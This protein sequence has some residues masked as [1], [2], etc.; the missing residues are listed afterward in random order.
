M[1]VCLAQI[2]VV[3]N[4]PE[5]N[6]ARMLEVIA[7][8]KRSHVDLVVFPEMCVGGY[9]LGDKWREPSY[10]ANMT[11]FNDRLRQA[12]EGIAIAYGNVF[13]DELLN[14]RAG[15]PQGYHPN[16]D[17]GTRKYNAVYV[18]DD[19]RPARRLKET[20]LLPPGVV[21]KTIL[22]EYR[23]FD[24][25]RYFFSTQDIAKD[26]GVKLESL[27]QP[28]VIGAHGEQVPVGFELCEDM[29]CED[30]R[31][32]GGALNP[33]K[34][35]IEN[36]AKLVVNLSASPWTFGKNKTRDKRVKFLKSQSGGDFVPFFYVNCVGVQNNGKDFA[37][38]DG[39]STVYSEEGLP[40]T[41]SNSSYDEDIRVVETSNLPRKHLS[42]KESAR[43]EQQFH[44]II[45]GIRHMN[46]ILGRVPTY[47]IGLSGGVDSAVVASLLKVAVGKEKVIGVNMPTKFNSKQTRD[48]A[49]HVAKKLGIGF[50]FIPIDDL[51]ESNRR[52]LLQQLGKK[53]LDPKLEQNIQAK[54]RTQILS[55]LAESYHG[56]Y[57]S[58]GNKWEIATGYSTLDGDARGALCP[59]GDLTKTEVFKMA[60]YLNKDV[61]KQE[62]IPREV[63]S[64]EQKPGAEL[65]SDQPNPLK[66]GYHCALIEAFMDFRAKSAE[67]V[68]KWYLTGRLEANLGITTEVIKRN[69]V[70][71]TEEFVRDMDWF[72]EHVLRSVFK[73]VQGPPIILLSKTAYGY[74]RR[75]SI[76]PIDES[77][78]YRGLRTKILSMERYRPS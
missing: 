44:G 40:V 59:I 21:P 56:L 23:I 12:S 22:P 74:D 60:E 64:M 53:A 62:V 39:G 9:L 75:E 24:D 61:F 69:D 63:V 27:L 66:L 36:G 18:F 72:S 37:L 25:E 32:D 46:D 13:L 10:C 55:N 20:K 48:S 31:R 67:D 35:L 68:M 29:W 2:E 43:T 8:A 5:K 65:A 76:L 71:R 47:V 50:L 34:I 45:R 57:T 28:L 30:Y 51:V 16:K 1:K 6:V 58:N 73:R 41:L 11:G 52:L 38:F 77:P 15:D 4:K 26:F 54:V 78:L 7:Q 3:P 14:E 19:G 42:R 49:S 17:G 70:D 33:T